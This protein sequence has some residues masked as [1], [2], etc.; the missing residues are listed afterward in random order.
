[1]RPWDD[2][3]Y[4]LPF[5]LENRT[6]IKVRIGVEDKQ[7]DAQLDSGAGTTQ[8]NGNAGALLGATAATMAADRK[9]MSTGIDGNRVPGHLHRFAS[10]SIGPERVAP[11]YMIVNDAPRTLLGVATHNDSRPDAQ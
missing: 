8:L 11:A 7:V 10:L 6:E 4:E 9:T 1:M 2:P 3:F 5:D